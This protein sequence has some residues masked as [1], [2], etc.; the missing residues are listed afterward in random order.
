MQ[1]TL[2]KNNMRKNVVIVPRSSANVPYIGFSSFLHGNEPSVVSSFL[3]A[4][5]LMNGFFES[6]G[7]DDVTFE[8]DG[9]EEAFPHFRALIGEHTLLKSSTYKIKPICFK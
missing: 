4:L 7:I 8:K 1:L 2:W 5:V 6:I 9:R 3:K